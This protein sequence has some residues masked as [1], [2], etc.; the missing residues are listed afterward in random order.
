LHFFLVWNSYPVKLFVPLAVGIW[1]LMEG[2]SDIELSN[3]NAIR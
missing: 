2:Q 1:E 3:L